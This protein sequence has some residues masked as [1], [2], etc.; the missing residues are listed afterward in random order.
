V[1]EKRHSKKKDKPQDKFRKL[2]APQRLFFTLKE[3]TGKKTR[4]YYLFG[5]NHG[6]G[7]GPRQR[8][9]VGWVKEAGDRDKR[10]KVTLKEDLQTKLNAISWGGGGGRGNRKQRYNKNQKRKR[11][12]RKVWRKG[13]ALKKGK[14]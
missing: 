13:E 8:R 7:R 5:K 14:K 12:K 9:G 1:Y 2:H 11:E 10:K 4:K 3:G 6:L